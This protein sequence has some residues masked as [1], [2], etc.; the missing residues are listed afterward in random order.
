MAE[1]EKVS[2]ATHEADRRDAKVEAHAD[3]PP[4]ADEERE[5][6]KNKL[7]PDEARTIKEQYER[8]ANA[9]GEGR[10]D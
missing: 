3:R 4:T 9:K 10:V 8:G 6:E 7:D 2:N 1:E 5:A